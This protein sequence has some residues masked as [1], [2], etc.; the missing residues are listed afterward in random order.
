MLGSRRHHVKVRCER[1]N[2]VTAAPRMRLDTTAWTVCGS[3][4]GSRGFPVVHRGNYY[5]ER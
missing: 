2:L 4:L 5:E 1:A 3:R